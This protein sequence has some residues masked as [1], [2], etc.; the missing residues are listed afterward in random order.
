M[1]QHALGGKDHQRFPPRTKRL[2]PE[3]MKILGCARRLADLE[4]VEGR[5]LKKALDAG[6]GMLRTL[7]LVAVRQQQ[8]DTRKQVPLSLA[9]NDELVNN[10]LRDVGE[11]AE[12]GF[13][14]DQR[15]RKIAAVA[16]L[17]AED[18]GFGQS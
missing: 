13:P 5:E 17:K 8:Y 14:Q 2:P 4:I 16:I 7:P 9:G 15:F 18:A 12:L 10:G 3:E 11:V 1:S 6:A